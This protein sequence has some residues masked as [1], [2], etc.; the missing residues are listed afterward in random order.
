[1]PGAP[2]SA[3]QPPWSVAAIAAFIASFL[4]CLLVPALLGLVLGIIGIV[5]SSGGKRRG[6][7]L[8]IAALPISVVTAAIGV[9]G[10][11][12]GIIAMNFVAITSSLP[13]IF[14][15]SQGEEAMLAAFRD[16]ASERLSLAVDDDAF[17]DW[18][19]RV[20][21][22]RGKLV[23]IEPP[24][25]QGQPS[26]TVAEIP[27]IGKFVNEDAEILIVVDFSNLLDPRLDN[28]AVDGEEL[29]ANP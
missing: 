11:F 26:G 12:M 7:G 23:E 19:E 8:A 17:R 10:V 21:D 18:I 15:E 24:K 1:M 3:A 20:T 9:F 14:D 5:Q 27:L 29:V 16:I 28:I 13:Q 22:E 4:G 25:R 2:T 6:M